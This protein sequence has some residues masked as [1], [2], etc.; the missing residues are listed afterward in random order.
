LSGTR[1]VTRAF[2]VVLVALLVT[3]CV[4]VDSTARS[5]TAPPVAAVNAPPKAPVATTRPTGTPDPTAAPTGTLTPTAS[6]EPTPSPTPAPVIATYS[7]PVSM[8]RRSFRGAAGTYTWESVSFDAYRATLKWDVRPA[9]GKSCSVRWKVAPGS[10]MVAS[11][12]KAKGGKKSTGS[13]RINVYGV[14]YEAGLRV[15]STCPS[16]LLTIR[17]DTT[18]QYYWYCWDKG[19][20]RP[21][22]LGYPVSTDHYCSKQELRESGW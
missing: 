2:S 17:A 10:P 4:T 1:T 19:R 3:G 11:T 9:K 5:T 8:G 18:S 21:H 13:K 12:I 20:P 22:H 16:W 7:D 6:P 15:T 14:A